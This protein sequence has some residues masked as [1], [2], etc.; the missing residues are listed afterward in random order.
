MTKYYSASLETLSRPVAFRRGGT[1]HWVG[2]DHLGGTVRIM[3]SSFTALDGMRY[4]PYGED[5]DTG[6]SLNTDRKFTGQTEDEAA[7]LYWYASRAYDP[8]IGRFVSPDVLVPDP[9]NPQSLN[10]YAYVR[11]NPLNFVDPSG[12]S[13][14]WFNKAWGDEFYDVHGRDPNFADYVYR[15]DSMETVSRGDDWS[16]QHWV[17]TNYNTGGEPRHN[18]LAGEFFSMAKQGGWFHDLSAADQ[19]AIQFNIP[20]GVD[21]AENIRMSE[22]GGPSHIASVY[23][24][25]TLNAGPV[26]GAM[27]VGADAAADE[28]SWLN[29]VRDYGEWDYKRRLDDHEIYQDFGNFNFGVT[30][31]ARG[32]S[33]DTL[34]GGAYAD[35][36]FKNAKQWALSKIG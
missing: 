24:R 36:T 5:R 6:S 12:H 23:I 17:D 4:K 30:G 27:H 25:G 16:D 13:D 26:G 22:A 2:S 29:R 3:D 35:Q 20:V 15:R 10:R 32:H 8:D 9:Y 21:L 34:L 33:L 14:E 18:H 31:A 1:L 7:G 28:L 19:A 11:N